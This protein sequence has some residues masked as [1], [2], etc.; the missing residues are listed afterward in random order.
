[1]AKLIVNP[2]SSPRRRKVGFVAVGGSLAT[3]RR[4]PATFR[5]SAVVDSDESSS[6]FAKRMEQAWIISQ[7]R[8]LSLL[9]FLICLADLTFSST[10]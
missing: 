8:H 10:N 4:F 3:I 5:A 7:V 2:W 6:N 9:N 1:M